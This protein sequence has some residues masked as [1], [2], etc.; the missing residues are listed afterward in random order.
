MFGI[1]YLDTCDKA[2]ETKN[3][4]CTQNERR[5]CRDSRPDHWAHIYIRINGTLQLHQC[6]YFISLLFI[7]M[8]K[9]M[10][11]VRRAIQWISYVLQCTQRT[12]FHIILQSIDSTERETFTFVRKWDY[13]VKTLIRFYTFS[14][15]HGSYYCINRTPNEVNRFK[16]YYYTNNTYTYI[17]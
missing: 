15:T 9:A 2:T 11:N 10:C 3:F 12:G 14:P 8:K 5:Q 16:Y 7:I 6:Q 17:G 4:Y 1:R 13:V